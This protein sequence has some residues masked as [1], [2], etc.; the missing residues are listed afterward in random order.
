MDWLNEG[1]WHDGWRQALRGFAF[2]KNE[3]RDDHSDPCHK[4]RNTDQQIGIGR[5]TTTA[6]VTDI[7]DAAASRHAT[8]DYCHGPTHQK[9]MSDAVLGRAVRAARAKEQRDHQLGHPRVRD[10]DA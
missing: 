3:S 4:D 10:F 9:A 2:A 8:D 5:R 6:A 1:I 7:I